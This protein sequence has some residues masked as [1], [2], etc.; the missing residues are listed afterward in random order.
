MKLGEQSNQSSVR[1][2][3]SDEVSHTSFELLAF[4]SRRW[5]RFLR[6]INFIH[7][8]LSTTRYMPSRFRYDR[9]KLLGEISIDLPKGIVWRSGGCNSNK[10]LKNLSRFDICKDISNTKKAN[11]LVERK[12]HASLYH[13]GYIYAFGGNNYISLNLSCERYDTFEDRWEFIGSLPFGCCSANVIVLDNPQSIYLFGGHGKFQY[14][15][16]SILRMD[17]ERLI[18]EVLPVKLPNY[19]ENP[20]CFKIDDSQVFLVANKELHVFDLNSNTILFVKYVKRDFLKLSGPC[21][22]FKDR[23][24]KIM[25]VEHPMTFLVGGI[26]ANSFEQVS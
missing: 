15:N 26:Y 12:D 8:R 14:S 10:S 13:Q 5:R 24:I 16:D 17:F 18:W 4:T 1:Q 25:L 11:M 6:A 2:S 9:H 7:R 3:Q 20:S 22:L 23:L 19:C 21:Y